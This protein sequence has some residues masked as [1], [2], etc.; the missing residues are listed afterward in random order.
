MSIALFLKIDGIQGESKDANHKGWITLSGFNG[1]ASLPGN[2]QTGG[3][4]R[5]SWRD[6]RDN[7]L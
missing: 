3:A 6:R 1:A 4:G 7:H 2:M 5:V